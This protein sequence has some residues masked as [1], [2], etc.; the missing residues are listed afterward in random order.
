MKTLSFPSVDGKCA[1]QHGTYASSGYFCNSKNSKAIEPIHELVG[2]SK[3][4]LP[5][6]TLAPVT[7][8]LTYFLPGFSLQNSCY[9]HHK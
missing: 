8:L 1:C 9:L 5:L 4:Y 3:I 2:N 6:L 7:D